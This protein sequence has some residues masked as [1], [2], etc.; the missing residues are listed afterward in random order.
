L[1]I[2]PTTLF[3]KGTL[4]PPIK[5]QYWGV[6]TMNAWILKTERKETVEME[7][8]FWELANVLKEKKEILIEQKNTFN[9]ELG[10]GFAI[11]ILDGNTPASHLSKEAIRF[12]ADLDADLDI[13]IYV[14]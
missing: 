3:V 2:Q 7:D 14:D 12:I 8:Q 1:K 9:L 6:Y 10:F 13:D 11:Y 4:R 5:G